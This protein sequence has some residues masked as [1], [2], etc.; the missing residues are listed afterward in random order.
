MTLVVGSVRVCLVMEQQLCGASVAELARQV[1]RVSLGQIHDPRVRPFLQEKLDNRG[2]THARGRMQGRTLGAVPDRGIH[3]GLF[4]QQVL[5]DVQVPHVRG[6]HERRDP[7]VGLR[8]VHV[9]LGLQQLGCHRQVAGLAQAHEAL[10]CQG[11][12]VKVRRLREVLVDVEAV[13]LVRRQGIPLLGPRRLLLPGAHYRRGLGV[14]CSGVLLH[15]RA[16]GGRELAA[17][18]VDKGAGS[19]ARVL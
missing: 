4:P 18:A 14:P 15:D 9:R 6:A 10:R 17:P 5:A 3:I 2:K 16:E 11:E 7:H 12:A 13:V 19:E 8:H 1:Q